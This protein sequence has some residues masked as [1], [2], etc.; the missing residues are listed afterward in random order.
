MTEESQEHRWPGRLA[1]G[2]LRGDPPEVF[3][4]SSAAVLG[5]VLALR[6]VARSDPSELRAKGVLDDIRAALLEERWA[7]AV[8]AWMEATGSTIDGY[9]DEEVW[10][11]SRLDLEFTALELRMTRIFGDGGDDAE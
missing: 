3:L 2:V 4:A 9:P 1:V 8:V 7:D 10:T 6:L 11:D 5:R